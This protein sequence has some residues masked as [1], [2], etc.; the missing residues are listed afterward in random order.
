MSGWS[1][2]LNAQRLIVAC[3]VYL[4]GWRNSLLFFSAGF[5]GECLTGGEKRDQYCPL[6]WMRALRV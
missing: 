3:P 2:T 1:T 5:E 4:S 6:M